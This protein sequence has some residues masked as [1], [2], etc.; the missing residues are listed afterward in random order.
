MPFDFPADPSTIELAK[1]LEN[2]AFILRDR[3]LWPK[4]FEWNYKNCNSC[5][6]GM[7]AKLWGKESVY[8][9]G[10]DER[11]AWLPNGTIHSNASNRIFT[12]LR[13]HIGKNS[14]SEITPEDV[15]DAID[16]YLKESA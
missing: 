16:A 13:R 9:W 15:A 1:S 12:E 5:A 14:M 4:G 10:E 11:T 2:L 8:G 7:A 6:I 3:R